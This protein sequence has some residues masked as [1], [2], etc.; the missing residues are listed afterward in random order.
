VIFSWLFKHKLRSCLPIQLARYTKYPGL[1]ML[2]FAC[3]ELCAGLLAQPSL[4]AATAL[5]GVE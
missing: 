5:Q 2:N 4:Q 1:A 3:C